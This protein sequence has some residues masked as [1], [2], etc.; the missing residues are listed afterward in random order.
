M[1]KP[2]EVMALKALLQQKV[3]LL[4]TDLDKDRLGCFVLGVQRTFDL[5]ASLPQLKL[6]KRH[7]RPTTSE[8][9]ENNP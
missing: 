5:F 6:E 2:G 9:R 8:T 7:A 3:G 1:L 4:T